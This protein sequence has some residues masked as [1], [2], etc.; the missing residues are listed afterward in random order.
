MNKIF[1][2]TAAQLLSNAAE[3]AAQ[4]LSTN[5]E[6]VA[7]LLAT[8]AEIAA[9]LLEK[10]TDAAIAKINKSTEQSIVA[11]QNYQELTDKSIMDAIS[12]KPTSIPN[13]KKINYG[14]WI[15]MSIIF[16]ILIGLIIK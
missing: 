1:T 8:N 6:I 3:T 7:Q 4:L 11:M 10:S 13:D 15:I 16:V 5:A 14:F 9:Q 12:L 2:E